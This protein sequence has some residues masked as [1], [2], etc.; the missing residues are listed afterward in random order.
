MNDD[1]IN[2]LLIAKIS[3]PSKNINIFN[4]VI[5]VKGYTDKK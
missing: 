3:I 1:L 4:A 2:K 5:L